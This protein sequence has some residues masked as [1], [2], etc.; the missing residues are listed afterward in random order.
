MALWAIKLGAN[1]TAQMTLSSIRE[2]MPQRTE[3]GEEHGLIGV[4]SNSVP[5]SEGKRFKEKDRVAMQKMRDE[6]S[7]MVKARFINTKGKTDPYPVP[8]MKWDG[9]PILTYKLLPNYDYEVPKGLVDDFNNRQCMERSGLL[10]VN[11]K[12]LM[13]DRK[14]SP[15]WMFVAIGF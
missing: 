14:T 11:G 5:N 9:D 13:V 6:Q 8:Y 1:M 2:P 10:D 3:S 12:P 4:V 15:E 7:R